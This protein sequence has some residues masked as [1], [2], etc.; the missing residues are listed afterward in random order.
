MKA[1]H[2][3]I[4]GLLITVSTAALIAQ[5]PDASSR[6]A[7]EVAT[8]K[9]NVTVDS[10]GGGGMAPGGRFRLVNMDVRTLILIA[11]RAAGT[12][13]FPSQ[14]IG[15]P[16]WTS[17]ENYD[18]TAKVGDDL[19]GKPMPE[20]FRVQPLLLQSL[21]A[22]RFK[23]KVH[24]ETRDLPRYALVLARKDGALGPQL[25]KSD[26]DCVTAP[27]RCSLQVSPGRFAAGSEPISA[28]IAFIAPNQQRVVIDRTGLQGR[29]AITLEWMPDRAPLP[30][31]GD[32][33]PP[34]DKPLL[35]TA[36][37]DQLGL[38]LESERGPVDVIVIDRVERPTED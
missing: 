16:G 13:L 24:R 38:K 30:L 29:Y 28:L 15:A 33:P 9:R 2:A 17:T 25:Q 23:L 14:L 32:V 35:G 4:A 6:P 5:A 36:L 31:N 7:F 19:A 12:Q 37:Q 8:I 27:A 3:A 34:S 10:G 11:Y 22:D 20:L 1:P 21:L 26:V 18:I